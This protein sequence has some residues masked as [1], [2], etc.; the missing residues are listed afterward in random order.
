MKRF[1]KLAA[2]AALIAGA[3][4]IATAAPAAAQ[5]Y[6]YVPPRA[7]VCDPYSRYY[8]PFVCRTRYNYYGGGPVIS[9]GFGGGWHDG[10]RGHDF[11]GGNWNR[12]GG[13][14][15]FHG[16]RGGG[17]DNHGSNNGSH[18]NSGGHHR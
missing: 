18:A 2:G 12:G 11:R 14:H 7:L 10:W 16:G 8:D 15:D 6:G 9:F 13:G 1:W 17:H 5:P 4:S 3:A